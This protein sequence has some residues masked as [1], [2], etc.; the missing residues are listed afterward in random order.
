MHRCSSFLLI[1]LAITLVIALAGCLGGN[2]A[3]SG[4][5]GVKNI[6]LNPGGN[7][8]LDVGGTLGFSA[9][10]TDANGRPIV[11]ADIQFIVSSPPGSTEP[12]PLSMTSGGGA[13]AGTWDVSQSLCSA[14]S[15]GIAIVTAVANG[16]RSPQT[17]VYVHEH[18]ATLQVSQAQTLPPVYDC[19]SQGQTWLYQG[20]AYDMNGSE[21]TDTVG[22]LFWASTN[23]GVLTTN[24]N[25]PLQIPLPLN[26][27]QITAASPGIT[28]LSAS[29][30]GTSSNPIPVTTCLVESVRLQA[31]GTT[32]SSVN[33]TS[34]SSVL[35]QATVV[36]SLGFTLTKPPLT[37]ISSDP[38]VVSFSSLTNSSGTNSATARTNQGGADISALCAPPTCNIGVLPNITVPTTTPPYAEQIPSAMP[39]YVFSSDGPLSPS[40]PTPG[41]GTI[42]VDVLNTSPP[43]YTG[44]VATDQCGDTTNGCTS[45]MFAATPTTSG[46]KNPIGTTVS[47]P[48]TPNSMMFNHQS[49]IYLGSNQ[50]LMYYDVGGSTGVFTVSAASTPCNLA[51]CGTVL[52]VSSDGKQVV[53]SDGTVPATPQVYIYNSSGSSGTITDLVLP[54]CTAPPLQNCVASAAA[55]S[56]DESKIFILTNAATMYV[57]STVN[58]LGSVQLPVSATFGTAA[59]FSPDG[60]FAYVAGATESV[61]STGNTGSVS[62][63]STCA[64]TGTPSTNLGTASLPANSGAP[65]QIFPA[66]LV[67]HTTQGN[68]DLISQNIY[69]FEPPYIQVLTAQFAQD[70]NTIPLQPSKYTCNLPTLAGFTALPPEEVQAGQFTPVYAKLVNDGADIIIVAR[71]IPAVLIFNVAN[72]TT[73]EVQLVNSDD[74]CSASASSDGSQVFV[75]ACDQHLPNSNPAHCADSCVSGS[76][77]LVNT[78]N[79]TDQQV[80]YIN[81]TTNNMCEGQGAGAPV[82]FP[83]LVA[84]KP[85]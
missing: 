23:T 46:G 5:G 78:I 73:R 35:L 55:F 3:N 53:V 77:H 14:G 52:A 34:G 31:S 84:I 63:F 54:S 68:T 66:P 42:S 18:I 11:G 21:I 9:S 70:T 17:T 41:Y 49:R 37:W 62:A 85:Q 28:Q 13:C 43:T 59:A 80:P 22:Q 83:G 76:V 40:D 2:T 69:V 10:A 79:G 44:W 45:V 51:L 7:L 30:S 48:R 39:D 72:G 82:C 29:I 24:T 57:Y 20:R 32:A 64:L 25:P 36:D 58:A 8:S 12:P 1:L 71:F 67:Q 38:E 75:A 19:F 60:S 81:N 74:P 56:P 6:S 16:V 65:L 15:P 26:Q 27:V 50:G 4:N 33:V 61:G 47:V